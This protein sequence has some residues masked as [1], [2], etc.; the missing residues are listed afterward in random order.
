MCGF[1]G[2][3]F[4]KNLNVVRHI[5]FP[6]PNATLLFEPIGTPIF[7]WHPFASHIPRP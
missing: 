3:I 4:P 6:K 2:I 5:R 7:V 1:L